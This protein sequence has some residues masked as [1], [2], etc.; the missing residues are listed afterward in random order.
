M[1]GPGEA[2]AEPPPLAAGWE[3]LLDTRTRIE[4]DRP[5]GSRSAW[6]VVTARIAEGPHR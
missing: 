5:A 4:P 3:I 2:A 6:A 1:A